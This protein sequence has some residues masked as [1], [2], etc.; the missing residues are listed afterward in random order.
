MNTDHIKIVC[1][2]FLNWP[3]KDIYELASFFSDSIKLHIYRDK[4]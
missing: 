4:C 3:Q 2:I 1:N